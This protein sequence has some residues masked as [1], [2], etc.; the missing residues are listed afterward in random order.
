MRDPARSLEYAQRAFEQSRAP[1]H[2]ETV[3]LCLS[4]VGRFD[5]A[6]E[7]QERLLA[8]AGQQRADAAERTRLADNLKRYRA[9]G[10]GRLPFD[11]G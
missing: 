9:R 5:E 3:A 7:L 4:A 1:Q 11:A 6:V 2:A 10:L 8:E